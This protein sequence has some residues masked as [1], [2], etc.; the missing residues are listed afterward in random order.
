MNKVS[1][2]ENVNEFEQMVESVADV[3]S[4]PHGGF[5]SQSRRFGEDGQQV[6]CGAD[7]PQSGQAGERLDMFFEQLADQ[8]RSSIAVISDGESLTYQDLDERSNQFARLLKDRGVAPGDRIGLL[9]DRSAETYITLLAVMK[10][11]AA[12]VPLATAFPEDRMALIIEDANV[13]LVISLRAYADRV[14]KMPVPHVLID[15]CAAA[16]AEQ[17]K[18]RFETAARSANPDEI[19]YILYT[20]G[21]DRPRRALPSGI[22]ASAIFSASLRRLWLSGK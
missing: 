18:A 8:Y 19:C 10:A 20:V 6:L 5:R 13:K 22:R 2:T 4:A 15:D 11:G 21:D 16:I 12:Y 7:F 14:E 9:L 1:A 17:S 3:S